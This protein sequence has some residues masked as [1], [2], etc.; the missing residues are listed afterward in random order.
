MR[1]LH[2]L[3][4]WNVSGFVFEL[5]ELRNFVAVAE[6]LNVSRAAEVVHIS[7]SALTRQIQSLERKMGVALFERLGKRL[8][9]T[10]EG[11]DLLGRAAALLDHA[12]ELTNHAFGLEQG[13]TGL[14]RVAASPQTNAWLMSPVI[15]EFRRNF[16]NVDLNLSEGHNDDLLSYV[17]HGV[18][19]VSV[20][21]LGVNNLLVGRKLFSAQIF[22]MLPPN[23]PLLGRRKVRIADIAGD[24]LLVMRRGFLTRHLFDQACAAHQVRPR[25]FLESDSTH[26]LVALARDGH[27]VAIVSTSA[28]DTRELHHATPIVSARCETQADVSAIWN[29]NRYRPACLSAFV[30]LLEKHARQCD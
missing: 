5:R 11:E 30:E 22:A 17:E 10:A 8:I 13:H 16:P 12:Q 29:P 7:Q 2:K 24:D 1:F 26:T 15:A 3:L 21:H 23:H 4:R 19:H 20:A 6:R 14:L 25:I 9:L 27:G 18:A 28:R